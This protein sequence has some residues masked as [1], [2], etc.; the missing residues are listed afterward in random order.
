MTAD[1]YLIASQK[2]SP[3]LTGLLLILL[4]RTPEGLMLLKLNQGLITAFPRVIV[5]GGIG[6]TIASELEGLPI[7][8][9]IPAPL[10]PDGASCRTALSLPR[11]RESVQQGILNR[12]EFLSD[13]SLAP[14]PLPNLGGPGS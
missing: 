11:T 13:C 3:G 10:I 7:H 6:S 9:S 12:A 4:L 2:L 8:Y 14:H 1:I 5:I